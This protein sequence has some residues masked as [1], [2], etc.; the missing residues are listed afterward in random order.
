MYKTVFL[1]IYYCSLYKSN[2]KNQTSQHINRNSPLNEL[3]KTTETQP[4]WISPKRLVEPCCDGF[5]LRTYSLN[6][7]CWVFIASS[8]QTFLNI[9][10]FTF[11]CTKWGLSF[12][13]L[14]FLFLPVTVRT[15]DAEGT[16]QFLLCGGFFGFGGFLCLGGVLFCFFQCLSFLM[17][18]NKVSYK[19]NR[20]KPSRIQHFFCL[21]SQF[22][23]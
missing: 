23:S 1:K 9:W 17:E 2:Q 11:C 15:T 5:A 13:W 3:L 16:I 22:I 7:L 4:F 19:Q 21:P 8:R 6:L 20:T 12:L 18:K 14:S 10:L